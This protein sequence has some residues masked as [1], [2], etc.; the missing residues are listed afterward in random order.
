MVVRALSWNKAGL[1]PS[2]RRTESDQLLQ[3]VKQRRS[4]GEDLAADRQPVAC[5]KVVR[6]SAGF[7]H[8]EETR[9]GIPRVHVTLPVGVDASRRRIGRAERARTQ[10]EIFA[11]SAKHR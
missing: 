2:S 3:R 11:T 5:Q 10:S 4:C 9:R 1:A 6:R 8:Q 7:A